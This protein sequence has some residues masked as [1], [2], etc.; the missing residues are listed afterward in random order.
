MD[1][2]V[3]AAAHKAVEQLARVAFQTL[4][5]R[6]VLLLTA[7]MLENREEQRELQDGPSGG[8]GKDLPGDAP[9]V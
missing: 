2:K 9:C 8:Q 7:E 5:V 3:R 4:E 6:Q 1:M